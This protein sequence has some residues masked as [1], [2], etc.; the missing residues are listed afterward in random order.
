MNPGEFIGFQVNSYAR[1][2]KG[3]GYSKDEAMK[4]EVSLLVHIKPM[5]Q[6]YQ[7]NIHNIEFRI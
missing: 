2:N 6:V 7:K 1:E 4:E 5:P 3:E